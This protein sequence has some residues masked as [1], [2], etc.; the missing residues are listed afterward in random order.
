MNDYIN[1]D[2]RSLTL[3]VFEGEFIQSISL[4][5]SSRLDLGSLVR[6]AVGI[7]F[8]FHATN[9]ITAVASRDGILEAV[10]QRLSLIH[11]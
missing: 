9:P 1:H 5:A 8:V 11:I 3:S 4:L 6:Y 2:L 10:Q 7:F